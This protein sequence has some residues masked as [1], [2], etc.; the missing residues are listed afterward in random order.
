MTAEKDPRTC[1]VKPNGTIEWRNEADQLDSWN[2][3][4]ARIRINEMIT[5]G[6]GHTHPMRSWEGRK[7]W[8]KQGKMHRDNDQPAH[9]E[10]N[11][12]SEWWFEGKPRRPSG[13]PNIVDYDGSQQWTDDS[14]QKHREGDLPAYIKASGM[15]AWFLNGQS[16]RD[17][18]KPAMIDKEGRPIRYF[19]HGKLHRTDGPA[20]IDHDTG[21]R[22]WYIDGRKLEPHEIPNVRKVRI[23]GKA[24]RDFKP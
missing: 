17:D 12:Y 13:G 22:E 20:L 18:N 8:Y 1:T 9:V 3:L 21:E 6:G 7:E 24:Q 5:M 16:H 4:P 10:S 2:D 14:M 23:I 15:Q 19:K 11:G